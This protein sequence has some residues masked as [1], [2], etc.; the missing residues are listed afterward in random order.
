MMQLVPVQ[1]SFSLIT[2]FPNRVPTRIGGWADLADRGALDRAR[3]GMVGATAGLAKSASNPGVIGAGVR[4]VLSRLRP[5]GRALLAGLAL[6]DRAAHE[7]PLIAE[8]RAR[9]EAG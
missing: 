3:I 1:R 4:N 9:L 7:S 5:T 6:V 8:G 2:E